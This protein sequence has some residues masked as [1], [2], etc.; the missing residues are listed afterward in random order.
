MLWGIDSGNID[1]IMTIPPT[2][3]GVQI[4]QKQKA[5]PKKTGGLHNAISL[6]V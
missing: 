5:P 1:T 2:L 4:S 3:K 6:F